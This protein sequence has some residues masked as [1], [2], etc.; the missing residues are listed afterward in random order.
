VVSPVIGS[1]TSISVAFTGS[2]GGTPALTKY[3]YALNGSG[4]FQDATGTTSPITIIGL[5][6]GESYSVIL[7]AVSGTAWTS[8]NST[9]SSSVST[10]KVGTAPSNLTVSPVIGSQTS[11]SVAFTDSIGG[12]P[13]ITKYQYALNGSGSFLDAIGTTSPITITDLTAGESYTVILR[14]VSC[15]IWTSSNSTTSSSVNTYKIG[16][17]PVINTITPAKNSLIVNFSGST[18]GNTA[19]TTYLYSV[20]GGAY[21]NANTTTSPLTVIKLTKS[22][23][24]LT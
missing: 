22:K 15:S 5:T 20:D 24:Y 4:T 7:R 2:T 18:G 19:P 12:T 17:I 3:Q 21:V 11:I 8:S 1:Q 6:P 9:A 10:Y 14:A 16:S 13:S 23:A